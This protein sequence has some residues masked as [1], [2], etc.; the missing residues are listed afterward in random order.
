MALA[1]QQSSRVANIQPTKKTSHGNPTFEEE[2]KLVQEGM[3][4]GDGVAAELF[5]LSSKVCRIAPCCRPIA[6]VE[7]LEA[8]QRASLAEMNAL[9]ASLQHR[10]FRGEL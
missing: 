4:A 6:A 2:L 3:L 8:V 9:F 7:R 1:V 10:A 5:K